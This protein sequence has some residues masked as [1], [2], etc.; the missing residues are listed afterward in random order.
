MFLDLCGP[1]APDQQLQ[2]GYKDEVREGEEHRGML[3]E[4]A[5]GWRLGRS[6]FWHPSGI[7]GYGLE[8]EEEVPLIA[9]VPG[10]P[11]ASVKTITGKFGAAIKSH[12]KTI[13]YFRIPKSCPTGGF[14]L[15]A[16][17][18]FAEDGEPS[19]PEPVSA[20]YKA[21]CPHR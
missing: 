17:V 6:G 12:G 8:E 7:N 1:A 9:S 11:Y 3:P 2:H 21:P 15:K 5:R 10:A 13:Y 4:P 19:R 16:E 18:I 20:F 14:P